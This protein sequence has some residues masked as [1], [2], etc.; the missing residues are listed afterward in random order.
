[1]PEI[2]TKREKQ[3]KASFERKTGKVRETPTLYIVWG[4][5]IVYCGNIKDLGPADFTNKRNMVK[6]WPYAARGHR[7]A[8]SS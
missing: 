6:P 1:M 7:K 4:L 2:G 5:E 8:A 3:A